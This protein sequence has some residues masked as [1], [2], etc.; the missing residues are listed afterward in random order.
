MSICQ[1]IINTNNALRENSSTQGQVQYDTLIANINAQATQMQNA[2]MLMISLNAKA[3]T[4]LQ[5]ANDILESNN[6]TE[7]DKYSVGSY[8]A[9]IQVLKQDYSFAYNQIEKRQVALKSFLNFAKNYET[10]IK[11]RV[12]L[13]AELAQLQ[14]QLAQLQSELQ[15]LIN[16]KQPYIDELARFDA[17]LIDIDNAYSSLENDLQSKKNQIR[18]LLGVIPP[19]NIVA[20]DRTAQKQALDIKIELIK[21]NTFVLQFNSNFNPELQLE[22]PILVIYELERQS[23]ICAMCT[24]RYL[25]NINRQN[26]N[27][28]RNQ[29]EVYNSRIEAKN[30]EITQKNN[31]ISQKNSEIQNAKNLISSRATTFNTTFMQSQKSLVDTIDLSFDYR[32]EPKATEVMPIQAPLTSPQ[33]A[34]F[35]VTAPSRIVLDRGQTH[36]ISQYVDNQLMGDIDIEFILNNGVLE[37]ENIG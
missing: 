18:A 17:E 1:D 13:E 7:T 36:D 11:N 33:R 30:A 29:I 35:K 5:K 22:Y 4:M 24:N 15:Q 20:E 27:I 8:I 21:N 23:I 34:E 19:D 31:D 10:L 32:D 26:A 3:D 16:E 12:A 37:N 14:S 28:Q 6:F 9:K 2:K 25:R